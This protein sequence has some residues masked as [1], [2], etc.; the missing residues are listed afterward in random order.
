[1]DHVP[2]RVL[3]RRHAWWVHEFVD[4][5]FWAIAHGQFMPPVDATRW[6][7]LHFAIIGPLLAAPP[8]RGDLQTALRALAF[9]TWQHPITGLPTRFGRPALALE[10]MDQQPTE[11]QPPQPSARQRIEQILAEAKH[12]SHS[13]NWATPRACPTSK[14]VVVITFIWIETGDRLDHT[15]MIAQ[16]T[17][18]VATTAIL[19]LTGQHPPLLI[20]RPRRRTS[21]AKKR[22]RSAV[23]LP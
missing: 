20:I 5:R 14:F 6:A 17:F 7:R 10:V 16:P 12:R 4:T 15:E 21:N 22:C 1:V 11:P 19:H 9:R 2:R 8:A 13:G 23:N 3:E 18:F